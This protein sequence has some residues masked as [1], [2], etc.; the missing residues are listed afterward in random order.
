M[1][2]TA[3]SVARDISLRNTSIQ[4]KVS[5]VASLVEELPELPPE[6]PP[7]EDR[8]EPPEDD[9]LFLLLLLPED[10]L[11]LVLFCFFFSSHV[12][13]S[14]FVPELPTLNLPDPPENALPKE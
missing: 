4:S 3:I 10:E 14:A 12:E 7:D 5:S 2:S 13:E 9:P 1:L 6:E 11:G 8:V